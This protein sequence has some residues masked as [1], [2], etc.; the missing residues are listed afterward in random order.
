M[1]DDEGVSVTIILAAGQTWILYTT[2]NNNTVV[3]LFQLNMNHFH[4]L[5]FLS[6]NQMT[7]LEV[8]NE[9]GHVNMA[10]YFKGADINKLEVCKTILL[11]VLLT[12]HKN[13]VSMKTS[14]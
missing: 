7:P 9:R 11:V 10:A 13:V 8:A 1:K 5:L 2:N 14:T 3:S 4:L 12:S 6:L